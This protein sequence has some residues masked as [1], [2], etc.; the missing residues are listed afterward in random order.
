[1]HARAR[2]ITSL[3][4]K[5]GMDQSDILTDPNVTV[6]FGNFRQV[7][8]ETP[9]CVHINDRTKWKFLLMNKQIVM[10]YEHFVDCCYMT[11]LFLLNDL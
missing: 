4:A 9:A 10:C 11:L 3:S 8:G 2:E 7:N 6:F 1:M 5:I